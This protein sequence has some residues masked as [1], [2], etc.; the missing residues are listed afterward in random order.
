[1]DVAG[2]R[3]QPPVTSVPKDHR[4]RLTVRNH[5]AKV[6]VLSLSGYEDRVRIPPLHP[7]EHWTGE[8]LADRP[9]EDF[10]W[11]LNGEPAGR[12]AVTGQHLME[13]H[14]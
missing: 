2:G 11:V 5:D 8:F 13:G 10:A 6:A 9:G 1:V 4:V 3:V 12:L 7:R 14:R